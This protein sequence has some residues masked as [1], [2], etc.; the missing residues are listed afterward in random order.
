MSDPALVTASPLDA[1]QPDTWERISRASP[2]AV[3]AILTIIA[4]VL[5]L[6][7]LGK[8]SL[9]YDEG[10]SVALTHLSWRQMLMTSHEAALSP[11]Q[12]VLRLWMMVSGDSETSLRMPSVIFSV[13]TLPLL[14]SLAR[15]L[16]GTRVAVVAAILFAVNVYPIRYAQEARGYSLMVLM[17]VCSW[18]F[19]LRCF[20]APSGS[21]YAAYVVTSVVGVYTHVFSSLSYPA[22]WI[23]LAWR[24]RPTKVRFGLIASIVL[25]CLLILPKG[26]SVLVTDVGQSGWFPSLTTASISG[27]FCEFSGSLT[28]GR[29]EFLLTAIYLIAVTCGALAILFDHRESDWLADRGWFILL[30]FAFPIAVVLI[31]SLFKPLLVN[32]YLSEALP[33]FVIL[34]AAGLCRARP[35]WIGAVGLVAIVMLSLYQDYLYYRYNSGDDWRSATTY[36]LTDAKPG[37]AIIFMLAGSR[38]P[39][40]YYVSKSGFTERPTV[41]FPDWDPQFRVAGIDWA[42]YTTEP[43]IFEPI[44]MRAINDA[45]KRYDRI[46]LALWP[47]EFFQG[48]NRD[49][50]YMMLDA[51]NKRTLAALGTRYRLTSEKDFDQI[52]LLRYDRA[53]HSTP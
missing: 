28:T 11:Y 17:V 43:D 44:V 38:W 41:I 1:E 29:G 2:R 53:S 48:S 9:W 25:I 27:L 8:R 24:S 45:P 4:A 47:I 3:V 12:V 31:S 16:A 36:M 22:Q 52:H 10:L 19:F 49:P 50:Y 32:R 40:D 13:A 15:R 7:Y 18:I 46:W 35:R 23:P 5:R 34:C 51:V 42:R 14:Y 20:D 33:F 30:G 6:L 39:Y 21:N 26:L 37:D